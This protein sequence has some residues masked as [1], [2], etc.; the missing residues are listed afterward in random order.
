LITLRDI[1]SSEYLSL[2]RSYLTEASAQIDELTARLGYLER[3]LVDIERERQ[4]ADQLGQLAEERRALNAAILQL[5]EDIE[6]WQGERDRRQG[7]VHAKIAEATARILAL[8]LHTEA[9]F[10]EDSTVYFNFAEDRV[11]VNGKAGFSASSLT[12]LRNAFHLAL[13][14]VSCSD[15]TLRYPR[16]LLL[17]NIEDKGMTEQRSQN[18][19]RLLVSISNSLNVEHQIIFTTSMIDPKIEASDLTVGD[20]YTFE[21]KSLKLSPRSANS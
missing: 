5:R 1:T 17:D 7:V 4:L 13:Q 8:D 9:E 10:R 19:Q 16:F 3:E 18:F 6:A 15:Q 14:W 21:N 2:T 12:V 11:T 20:L